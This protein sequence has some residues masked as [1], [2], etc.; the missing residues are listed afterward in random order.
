[1]R[2]MLRAAQ[3]RQVGRPMKL[4]LLLFFNAFRFNYFF[5][6]ILVAVFGLHLQYFCTKED[7]ERGT[8]V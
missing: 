5:G 2:S 4:N 7:L 3:I 1:M 6:C 8:D